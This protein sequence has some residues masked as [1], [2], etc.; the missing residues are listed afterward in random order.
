MP[1]EVTITACALSAK[2]PDHGAR[3][4]RAAL[5]GGGLQD[6]A[7]DAVHHAGRLRQRGDAVAE[8]QR[9]EAR[10]GGLAHLGDERRDQRRAGAP[11]DVEARHRVAVAGGGVAA[12]L[13]PAD[14]RE[15]SQAHLVQP[16]A[17]L[18]GGEGDVGLGPAARPVVLRPVE[19]GG[20]H[21]VLQR[22]VVAVADAQAALLG[23]IH[24][25]EA[26][27]RPERLA[28]ED[29]LGLLVEEDDALAGVDQLSSRHE[30]G[31]PAADH[32]R[33]G[34][35]VVLLPDW[36]QTRSAPRV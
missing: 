20:A 26:A 33:I 15:P 24:E 19:A 30:A 12:A 32:D 11:G 23:R 18:A 28:A 3:G 16:G 27:E 31:E 36:C 25:H 34:I 10:L 29:L 1:P 4:G 6:V 7:G 9:D 35:H 13:G 5:H 22:Q 21:P 17:L 2:S 14:D 8:A